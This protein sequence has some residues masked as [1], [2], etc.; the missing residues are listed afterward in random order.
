MHQRA[1]QWRLLAIVGGLSLLILYLYGLDRMGMY[2][3]DEPRYA[4]IGREM[5]RSGDFITPRLWGEGWYE[6]PPL[7]Y[8]IIAAGFRAGLSNDIAPRVPVALFSVAFLVAFCWI[9]RREFGATVA[10]Y[11]T[12]ML[13][14]AFLW[15][16][17][18]E[19]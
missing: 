7:L 2:S 10:A 9:V 16:A 8:W 15:I 4:S 18:S 19:I 3:A 11:S 6:K 1:A 12:M 5:A 17:Y 13:A 14:T